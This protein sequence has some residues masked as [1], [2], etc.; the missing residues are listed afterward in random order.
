MAGH[1]E[2]GRRVLQE[3]TKG[4]AVHYGSPVEINYGAGQPARIDATVGDIA[5]EVES[6]VSKQVRGA[7]LDLICH[8]HP[9]KLL[10]LLPV[11]MSNPEVTAAQCGNIMKRFC[12][13]GPVRV[14]VLKGTGDSHQLAEDTAIVAAAL[15]DLGTSVSDKPSARPSL[16]SAAPPTQIATPPRASGRRGQIAD[17]LR[18]NRGDAYCDD[19]LANTLHLAQ[20]QQAQQITSSLGLSVGFR[21]QQREC[22]SCRRPKLSIW[23]V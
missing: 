12:P 20:R 16:A 8:A 3:A 5:V 4:G 10:V 7:V 15:T 6:R 19:C 17:F 18:R 2:Y 14:V 22:S 11:H 13:D 23:G 21:R 9:K 1:D